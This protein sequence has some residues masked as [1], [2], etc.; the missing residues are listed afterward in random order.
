V[1]Y[2]LSLI[3]AKKPYPE[4]IKRATRNEIGCVAKTA[5]LH[6]N[7]DLDLSRIA[8]PTQADLEIRTLKELCM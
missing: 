2:N 5:D 4:F 3:C 6:D 8:Q 7:L 1:K